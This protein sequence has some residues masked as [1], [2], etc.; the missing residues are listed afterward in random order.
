[1]SP[2]TAAIP[3]EGLPKR[4]WHYLQSPRTFEVAGCVCG[5]H[6]TQWSEFEKHVWCAKCEIDFIPAH[7]GVFDGPIAV[8]TAALLGVRFD[9]FN[10]ETQKVERYDTDTLAYVAED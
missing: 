5:N 6:D 4:K 1:M 10:L 3:C 8:K 7:A 2:A 9:R